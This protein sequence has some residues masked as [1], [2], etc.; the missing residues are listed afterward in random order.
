MVMSPFHS[1]IHPVIPT[2]DPRPGHSLL[3]REL[4]YVQTE[5]SHDLSSHVTLFIP[6][7]PDEAH[8]E[9]CVV[10]LYVGVWGMCRE[11]GMEG[12]V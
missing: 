3:R 6:T 8:T 4:T 1:C 7:F 11:E 12:A 10:G 2:P 5:A 9:G